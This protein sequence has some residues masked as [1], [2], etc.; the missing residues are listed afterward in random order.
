MTDPYV[1]Q[2][3]FLRVYSGV[4][5]SGDT[6][7]NPIKSKKERIG[8]MLQMH[9]NEREEIKE[10]RAGDIAAAVGLKD[11]TTGDTLCD[12]DKIIM[13]ER[14]EFPEPVISQAVEPKTKA[15]QEKMGIALNRLAQEDP[16]FRVHTDEESGQ[17]IISGMGELHLEILVDRMKREFGVEAIGRQ[18]AGGVSRD[19]PQ[20]R[21]R[22]PKASSSSSRVVA[23]NMAT[24]SSSSSRKRR[25]RDSNSSTRSR[26]AWS[27][28]NTSRRWKRASRKR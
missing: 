7:Y 20:R 23:A 12:P 3:T 18:A 26:A 14:M 4:L 2:L 13:L 21:S 19:D 16:S 5:N 6:V 27:R 15:D 9:A 24:S 25:A 1:G 8:R 11:V 10:V 22:T 28:A 17:T